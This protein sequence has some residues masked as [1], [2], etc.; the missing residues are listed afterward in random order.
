MDDTHA[1][2]GMRAPSAMRGG[3]PPAA[4]APASARRAHHQVP[5][6]DV[7]ADVERLRA[8]P[9]ALRLQRQHP[10]RHDEA[11]R[12]HHLPRAPSEHPRVTP[13]PCQGVGSGLPTSELAAPHDRLHPARSRPGR[14]PH[15]RRPDQRVGQ[16]PAGRWNQV[17]HAG[18]DG[19]LEQAGAQ[20]LHKRGSKADLVPPAAARRCQQRMAVSAERHRLDLWRASRAGPAPNHRP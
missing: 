16:L 11:H 6:R 18:D 9:V 7:P 20:H 12:A 5:E 10:A 3:A 19:K 8:P 2:L 1:R 14:G 15:L 4:R 17:R 13:C